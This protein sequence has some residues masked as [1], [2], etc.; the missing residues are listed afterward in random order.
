MNPDSLVHIGALLLFGFA[1]GQIAN[2][3]NFPRVSGY[4][5][6][7]MFL[8][9][10]VTGFFQEKVVSEELSIVTDIALG[11]IAFSIGGSLVLKSLKK[12]YGSILWINFA[13]SFGAF[14]V[15]T[16]LI[17]LISPFII[18]SGIVP[19]SFWQTF[20]PMAL[21]IGAVSAATAPAAVM[22]IVHECRAAGPF[23]TTLLA[24]VA[25]D[26]A[27]AIVFFSF[28]IVLANSLIDA[29]ALSWQIVLSPILSIL[30]ALVIGIVSG[31]IFSKTARFVTRSDAMLGVVGGLVLLIYGIA[32]SVG[33]SPL[34]ANMTFGFMV[35][36][37]VTHAHDIFDAVEGIEE[38]IF[39]MF[40]VLAGAHLDIAVFS[41]SGFLL[42][43]LIVLGRFTGKLYGTR[44]GA[45]I[46]HAP[47]T[48]REYLGL[49]LLP[50][51][52]VTVGLIL[53]AKDTFNSSLLSV[54]MVNAVLL[55]VIVNELI[56]PPLVRYAL[57]RAGETNDD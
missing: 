17:C 33:V 31:L 7:G 26:D 38:L 50:K 51:A 54:L 4:I 2:H 56:A 41:V 23:T 1:G 53:L 8:S 44:L 6:T 55:S 9:P 35:I 13:Q 36:N 11:I 47:K 5:V 32:D 48:V 12:L 29:E 15:T 14:L 16:L 18:N 39:S 20:F 52:G 3:F 42:A 21:I 37:F 10:S 24:V 40:F 22:A 57:I 43:G 45:V 19:H 46:S 49:A 27:T 25:L 28:A 30:I 34:I